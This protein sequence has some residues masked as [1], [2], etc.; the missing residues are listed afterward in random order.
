MVDL[1][2]LPIIKLNGN[3]MNFQYDGLGYQVQS[4]MDQN[5]VEIGI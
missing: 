3:A 4:I 5:N 2:D 1:E